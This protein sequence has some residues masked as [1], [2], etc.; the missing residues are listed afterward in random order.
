MKHVVGSLVALAS[1]AA[2]TGGSLAAI[3]AAPQVTNLTG[4]AS[5]VG[6]FQKIEWRFDLSKTYSNGL[7]ALD[8]INMEI[9]SG[10]FGLLGPNGAGKS[11]LMRTIASLQ[12]ADSGSI[13]FGDMDVLQQKEE[14]RKILPCETPSE[15]LSGLPVKRPSPVVL[16]WRRQFRIEYSR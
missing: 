8:N 13:T 16:R 1:V 3:G 12:E 9:G 5:S 2:L 14:V 6:Q 7:K 4:G 11:S 10:M 15:S